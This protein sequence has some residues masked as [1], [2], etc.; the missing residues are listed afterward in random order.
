MS[1]AFSGRFPWYLKFLGG[2]QVARSAH[3][4]G[5]CL[6]FAFLVGH[7]AMVIINGVPKEFAKIFLGSDLASS[8][9]ACLLYTSWFG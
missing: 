7:T 3:F 1:P 4:I 5:L 6:F 8:S 9:L 2:K